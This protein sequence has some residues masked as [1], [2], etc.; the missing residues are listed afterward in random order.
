MLDRF[1]YLLA[2][3]SQYLRNSRTIHVND[4]GDGTVSLNVVDVTGV[5]GA[6]GGGGGSGLDWDLDGGD[7]AGSNTFWDMEGGSP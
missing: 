3:I 4:N 5:P 2:P 7:P 1:R 6:G